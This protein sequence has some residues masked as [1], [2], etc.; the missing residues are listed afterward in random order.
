[1]LLCPAPFLYC[2]LD[3]LLISMKVLNQRCVE[4]GIKTALALNAEINFRSEFDRKHYFYFDLPAGYQITQQRLP[5]ATNGS[6]RVGW[7]PQV[8]P[9]NHL[10]THRPPSS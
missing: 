10:L 2:I 1:M 5:L 4:A 7:G 9:S 6:L 3:V 8:R